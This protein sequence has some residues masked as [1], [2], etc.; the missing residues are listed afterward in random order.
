MIIDFD[1]IFLEFI[2]LC[3]IKILLVFAVVKQI[4]VQLIY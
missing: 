3:H 4:K 2:L 1:T